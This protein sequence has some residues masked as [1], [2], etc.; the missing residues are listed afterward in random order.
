MF[1]EQIFPPSFVQK[2]IIITISSLLI[3]IH[4]TYCIS[5]RLTNAVT[6]HLPG[7]GD[8]LLPS[9]NGLKG[10]RRDEEAGKRT[11]HTVFFAIENGP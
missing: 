9:V 10:G 2:T 8:S 11:G 4:A 1:V 6:T 5:K 3:I 7:L